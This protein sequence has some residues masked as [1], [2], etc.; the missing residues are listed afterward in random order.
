VA[1]CDSARPPGA[2]S[3][4]HVLIRPSPFGSYA[5]GDRRRAAGYTRYSDGV[6]V[7][8]EARIGISPPRSPNPIFSCPLLSTPRLSL[9]VAADGSKF[10]GFLAA[11]R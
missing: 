9:A 5:R 2:K 4:F 1:A 3:S 10:L 7:G 11:A 6:A 8:S